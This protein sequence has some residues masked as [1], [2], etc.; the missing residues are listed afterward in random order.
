MAFQARTCLPVS[1]SSFHR[2]ARRVSTSSSFPQRGALHSMASRASR[3]CT[4]AAQDEPKPTRAGP[5][6]ARHAERRRHPR[7]SRRIASRGFSARG[8]RSKRHR[9]RARH[10]RPR[11]QRR[12]RDGQPE[13]LLRSRE[14]VHDRRRPRARIASKFAASIRTQS[15]GSTKFASP[16]CVLRSPAMTFASAPRKITRRDLQLYQGDRPPRRRAFQ[17]CSRRCM[18]FQAIGD[19]ARSGGLRST[20]LAPSTR[21]WGMNDGVQEG[22]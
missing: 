9:R 13:R 2:H 1:R 4:A 6:G 7:L 14:C 21:S 8:R 18:D 11:R 17:S 22:I 15:R 16:K 19:R 3:R 12:R 5:A 10:Q 20:V